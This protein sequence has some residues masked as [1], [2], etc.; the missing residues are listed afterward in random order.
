MLSSPWG[1]WVASGRGEKQDVHKDRKLSSPWGV[2]VASAKVNKL[3]PMGCNRN[4][5]PVHKYSRPGRKKQVGFRIFL[6]FLRKN[7]KLPGAN[8]PIFYQKQSSKK[9][10]SHFVC[11][12]HTQKLYSIPENVCCCGDN[13]VSERVGELRRLYFQQIHQ[14]LA[15]IHVRSVICD[16]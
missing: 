16:K 8:H 11:H 14:N 6:L 12:Q 5:Y 9:E 13:K 4:C 1:V 10:G 7:F 2:W 3:R 15:E